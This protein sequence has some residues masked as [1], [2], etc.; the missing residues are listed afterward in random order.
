MEKVKSAAPRLL[1]LDREVQVRD[2]FPL[3]SKPGEPGLFVDSVGSL[4]EALDRL[5]IRG[6][7]AV[8]CRIDGPGEIS[9]LLRIRRAAPG[10][11]LIALTPVSDPALG[12]LARESG[13]DEVRPRSGRDPRVRT[14]IERTHAVLEKSRALRLRTREIRTATRENVARSR[15]LT[16]GLSETLSPLL[17]RFQPL[18]IE[19]DPIAAHRFGKACELT[20][21]PFPLP[22]QENGLAARQYLSGED[23]FADRRK[24]PLPNLVL[25]DP[26]VSGG[27]EVLVWIR[28]RPEFATLPVFCLAA[29]EEGFDQAL[30]DGADYFYVKPPKVEELKGLIRS[31]VIRWALIVRA[32]RPQL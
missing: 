28:E 3:L 27:R 26:S 7:E 13:A 25:L 30:A 12:E 18:L 11:P 21:I 4:A 32:V 5:R 22:A 24:F 16:H 29:Q 23:L 14:L 15:V 6:Y 8:L 1:I 9:H 10:V 20:S 2:G 17:A 19:S 31:I